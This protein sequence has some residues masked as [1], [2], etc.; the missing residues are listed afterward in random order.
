MISRVSRFAAGAAIAA[1]ALPCAAAETS[2][3]VLEAVAKCAQFADA[4][5]RLRCFDAA[6]ARARSLLA[7][8]A[9]E[10][11]KRSLLEMFGFPRTEKPVTKA[12]EFGKPPATD[13]TREL[14][15]I[16]ASAIEFAKTGRG[17]AVFVLD[18]G[19]VWRQIDSDGTDVPP[20]RPPFKVTVEVGVLGSYNLTM[21]GFN[22][23]V[24]VNRLR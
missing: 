22:S 12:E 9:A 2:R 14:T 7:A 24:K 13:P 20:A 15:S 11:P 1:L 19:Q 3:D 4:G 18:N 5:E 8:P 6:A 16:T 21:E 10:P 23:L 17:K